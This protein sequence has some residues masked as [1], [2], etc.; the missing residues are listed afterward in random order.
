MFVWW[1]GM[2]YGII[3]EVD[4]SASFDVSDCS[5]TIIINGNS[6]P[7]KYVGNNR[8]SSGFIDLTGQKT[9]NISKGIANVPTAKNGSVSV[10][11]NIYA[12]SD[13]YIP[14]YFS[15]YIDG[16]YG[17]KIYSFVKSYNGY[18]PAG[19]YPISI[20][21]TVDFSILL[22]GFMVVHFDFSKLKEQLNNCDFYRFDIPDT[23]IDVDFSKSPVIFKSIPLHIYSNKS[24]GF[25]VY[26]ISNGKKK[27]IY[28]ANYR[29][30]VLNIG[31]SKDDYNS[32][33]DKTVYVSFYL[34]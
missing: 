3:V 34:A 15:N 11:V 23:S 33:D 13:T 25:D 7:V 32:S 2:K 20:N 28:L 5:G 14:G 19:T 29:D 22:S 30:G 16:Y 17:R 12:V 21:K 24:I 27:G 26:I 8:F 10:N 4:V 1:W 6:Y 31:I 18:I 9:A